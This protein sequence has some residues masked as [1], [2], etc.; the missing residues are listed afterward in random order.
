MVASLKILTERN[1]SEI[2]FSITHLQ[3]HI[4]YDSFKF[5]WKFYLFFVINVLGMIKKYSHQ[6]Y[7]SV[8]RWKYISIYHLFVKKSHPIL[9]SLDLQWPMECHI[10]PQLTNN[11]K[12]IYIYVTAFSPQ[13]KFQRPKNV[14]KLIKSLKNEISFNKPAW[15]MSFSKPATK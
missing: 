1:R 7:L 8:F 11:H 9:F 10:Q 6:T 2:E 14:Q 5:C 3:K 13:T 12:N 4:K 15:K